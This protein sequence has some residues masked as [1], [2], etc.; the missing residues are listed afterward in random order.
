[1]RHRTAIVPMVMALTAIGAS[2]AGAVSWHRPPFA[3]TPFPQPADDPQLA[4]APSGA[5]AFVWE[6]WTGAH[7][8]IQ[9]RSRGPR[10]GLTTTLGLSPAGV[11]AEDP[12]L[13]IS[14][15]G[16]TSVI[17]KNMRS[18]NRRVQIRTKRPGGAFGP[19]QTLSGGRADATEDRIAAGPQGQVAV[20]WAFG[21]AG[22]RA[23][24]FRERPAGGQFEPVRTI[25]PSGGGEIDPQIAYGP[26]GTVTVTWELAT[27]RD[28]IAYA[29]IRRPNAP[30]GQIIPLSLPQGRA[31]DVMIATDPVTGVATVVWERVTGEGVCIQSRTVTPDGHLG[32][33]QDLSGISR[34]A[35]DA[36]IAVAPDGTTTVLWEIDFT[37]RDM[38]TTQSRT[39]AAGASEWGPVETLTRRAWN[40]AREA[41]APDVDDPVVAVSPDGTFAA[42]WKQNSAQGVRVQARIR[43]PGGPWA[44][45]QWLSAPL[46]EADEPRVTESAQGVFSVIWKL[47]TGAQVVPEQNFGLQAV[48]TRR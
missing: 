22:R 18:W 7:W 24:Q 23:V 2:A 45:P 4:A 40:S 12:R 30:F 32:P 28:S 8:R 21:R 39:R 46:R 6:G 48:Q 26:D 38:K 13:A 47:A 3:V 20:A 35:S 16:S 27:G 29:R 36:D 14:P 5:V 37:N 17:W 41:T 11:D 31:S 1:M 42:V 43:P 34:H 25:S 33:I 10:G 19:T 9:T 44:A 15:D